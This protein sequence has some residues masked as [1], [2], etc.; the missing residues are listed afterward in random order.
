MA[1]LNLDFLPIEKLVEV[2]DDAPES[3]LNLFSEKLKIKLRED[4]DIF[5]RSRPIMDSR[6]A[7]KGVSWIAAQFLSNIPWLPKNTYLDMSEWSIDAWLRNPPNNSLDAIKG[8]YWLYSKNNKNL[9]K[10]DELMN[11][12]KNKNKNLD[13]IN[14]VKIWSDMLDMIL[15]NKKLN[16][17]EIRMIVEKMPSNWW[18]IESQNILLRAV[19]SEDGFKWL[20]KEDFPWCSTILRPQG[21]KIAIPGLSSRSHPGCDFRAL[22]AQAATPS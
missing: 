21:E 3:V 4:P 1:L 16:G 11:R 6:K 20:L 8:V 13:D 2:S 9:E 5:L 12:V 7:S 15:A 10:I 14:E 19:R 18:A 22:N 17:N